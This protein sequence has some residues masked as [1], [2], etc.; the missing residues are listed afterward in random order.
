MRTPCAAYEEHAARYE[1]RARLT[2]DIPGFAYPDTPMKIFEH[3]AM[4]LILNTVS[5]VSMGAMGRLTSN[6]MTWLNM[7]TKKLI[8]RSTRLIMQECG[9]DYETALCELLYSD[10]CIRRDS[11]GDRR[12]PA[13][14]TIARLTGAAQ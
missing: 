10:E 3:I 4:K 8:D 1:Q 5:T 9:V 13:Q 12:S 7:S 14:E 6:F 11:A 2:L